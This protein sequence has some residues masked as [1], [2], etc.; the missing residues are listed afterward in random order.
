M[1][2]INGKL[3]VEPTRKLESAMRRRNAQI[4]YTP[5][6][7]AL[8]HSSDGRYQYKRYDVQTHWN[9]TF[10]NFKP[11]TETEFE[12]TNNLFVYLFSQNSTIVKYGER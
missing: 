1:R 9:K 8:H 2:L 3:D 5:V 4:G 11:T 12:T 6:L 7:R 10:D